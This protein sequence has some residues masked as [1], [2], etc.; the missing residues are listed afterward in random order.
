MYRIPDITPGDILRE[1]FLVPL[2][3]TAYRLSKDT[4]I[5]ARRISEIIKG[6]RRITAD[7]ALCLSS[8][9]GNSPDFW[10]GL[11]AEFELRKTEKYTGRS[12]E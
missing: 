8:Y 12:Q 11:Q 7:T 2:N 10:L 9:F 6:R 5:P 3:L 4:H 1:E